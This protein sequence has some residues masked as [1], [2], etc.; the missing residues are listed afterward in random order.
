MYCSAYNVYKK[1]VNIPIFKMLQKYQRGGGED[2]ML[3][4]TG[5]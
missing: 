4:Y 3:R 5:I 2:H 1:V